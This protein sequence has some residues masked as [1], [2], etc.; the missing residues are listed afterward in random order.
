MDGTSGALFSIYLHSLVSGLLSAPSSTSVADAKTWSAAASHA[1]TAL[2]AVTPARPGDRTLMDALTPF[3]ETLAE[4]LDVKKSAR[5]AQ[6]G[7]DRTKGMTASLG[8]SVYVD[9]SNYGKV[10]DPGA[11]GLAEFFKGMAEA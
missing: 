6:D 8:R 7:A 3:V 9:A 4:T 10:P 1:L 2:Q 5:A 11:V